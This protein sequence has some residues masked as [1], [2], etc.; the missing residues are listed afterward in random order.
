PAPAPLF[1]SL[2]N[3]RHSREGGPASSQKALQG[4][5]R[6]RFEE[7]TNYPF[8]LSIDDL[9]D[10]FWLTTQTLDSVGAE[11]ICAFMQTA[12][13]SLVTALETAPDTPLQKLAVLPEPERQRVLYTW[14]ETEMAIPRDRCLHELFEEQ[15]R[16]APESTALIFEGESLSY[17]ELNRLANRLA[18]YLRGL[19]V[20]PDDRVGLCVERGFAMITGLLAILKSGAGYVPLDPAYPAER[21]R[22]MLKDALPVALLT[23]SHLADV[24]EPRDH[25]AIPMLLL[26]QDVAPWQVYP[27]ENPGRAK[28]GLSPVHLAYVIYTSGSTGT[29]KGV[30]V[31][32]RNLVNCIHNA[33]Q[34]CHLEPRDRL[35]QFA[36]LS[37]DTAA[38]EIFPP[39]IVGAAL[40]LSIKDQLIDP[41]LFWDLCRSAEITVLELPARFWSQFVSAPDVVIPNA[42][43]LIVIGGEEVSVPALRQWLDKPRHVQLLNA[44]G[45][46]EVTITASVAG[47]VFNRANL[48]SIGRPIGNTQIYILDGAREPVAIGVPGEIY[49][50]GAGVARGYLNRPDL[51][52]ERFVRN[53]F[54]E[55]TERMY[56]TGDLG[57]W[58]PDGTIEFLGRNDDQV[59]IRGFRI[60]LGEIETHLLERPE[61]R[62]AV[63]LAREDEPGDKRLVAYYVG[64]DEG[65][66]EDLRSH[67][68][69]RL[70]EYMVPAAYVR[71]D[72]MPLTPNG[73]LD[74]KA[75]PAPELEAYKSAGY[76][77]PVGEMETLLAQAFAEVLDLEQVG[78][79]ENFFE[80]GGHSLLMVKLLSLLRNHGVEL[81]IRNLFQTPT[82]RDLAASI[83]D[84][85][86]RVEVPPSLIPMSVDNRNISTDQ[87]E[88]SI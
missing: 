79:H 65:A 9:G 22:F 59:K 19:G 3:Y 28:L 54:V 73:K 40:V 81:D 53:P 30:M 45:P 20:K 75:L 64:S 49:I 63:V 5:T 11:R 1:S 29:P 21:L 17:A 6:L 12:L 39:L 2:L 13:E 36:S 58:H 87:I 47:P 34:Y 69:Q 10:G 80:L 82:V 57:R 32:H 70:P 44:Y 52:A 78:R 26:D 60:E 61:I 76:E 67:L 74:R 55:G 15:V 41:N 83:A 51:T 31:E 46:T 84:A 14:N 4:M 43:R 38:E 23:Q 24:L 16:R 8:E 18:H 56:R 68:Q 85:L 77:I 50:G 7:R 33:Q 62:E 37:F 86:P 66:A 25:S 71:L 72:E 42:V 88:M 48:S 27:E 35:L